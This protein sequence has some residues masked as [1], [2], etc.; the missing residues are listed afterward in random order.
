MTWTLEAARLRVG[1]N[2]D[3][4]SQDVNLTAAMAVSLGAA[5]AYCDRKFLLADDA[6]AFRGHLLPGFNVRRWPLVELLGLGP[7][8]PPA[9]LAPDLEPVPDGWRMD[10]ARGIVYPWGGVGVFAAVG[11]VPVP[12]GYA[13][14]FT[15]AYRGGYDPEELPAEL[16]A[17][18]WMTFDNVWRVTPGWGA[19][20]GSAGGPVKAFSIDGMTIQYDSAAAGGAAAAPGQRGPVGWGLLPVNAIGILD[21]YRAESAA[22]GA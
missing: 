20:A 10:A 15:L 11:S 19:A 12:A 21:F 2:A 14:G 9:V 5:E 1:L 16:E 13:G 18:L 17:A 6:E 7:L 3:D 22:L 4:T 8:P